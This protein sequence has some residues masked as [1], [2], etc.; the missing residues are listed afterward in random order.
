MLRQQLFGLA[1]WD[2]VSVPR[3]KR[4]PL[5]IMEPHP[6]EFQS[7]SAGSADSRREWLQEV[8]RKRSEGR[9]SA[10]PPLTHVDGL[11][12]LVQRVMCAP[13]AL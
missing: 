7:R 11:P 2:P 10:P 8:S 3:N 1:Q 4:S 12:F 5:G 13:L 6:A 9:P